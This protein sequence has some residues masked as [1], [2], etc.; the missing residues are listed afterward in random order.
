MLDRE[1]A[2]YQMEK[3]YIH[4]QGHIVWVLLS[5]SL[6]RD[7]EGAPLNFISQIQDITERKCAQEAVRENGWMLLESQRV[8]RVGSYR[9][10]ITSGGWTST[11]VLDEI[12]GITDPGFRKDIEGWLSLVHPDEREQMSAYLK[13]EVLGRRQDFDREYRIQRL[14]DH[15]ERWVHGLGELVADTGGRLVG[16]IGTL[17]DVTERKRAEAERGQV[18]Q[19]LRHSQKLEGIGRLA[20]GVAH[21]F[22]NVLGVITGFGEMAKR[23]LPPDHPVQDRL[24][25]MLKASGRAADLTRQMLAFSRK[26]VMHPRALDLNGVIEGSQKMLGRLIGADVELVLRLAPHLGTVLADPTQIGQVLM[27]LAVN[28]R[29]AMPQGGRLAFE[30]V[31]V[32][33]DEEYVRRHVVGRVGSYVMLA[34]SDTGVGMDQETRSHIFE[35][36]FTTKA[37]GKG[38]G[39]G[40]ATV[41]GIVKQSD[42]FIWVYSEPGYGA[43]FRIYL[44]RL[45]TPQEHEVARPE[46]GEA[47]RGTETVLVVEDQEALREVAQEILEQQGYRVLV[48]GHG[49]SALE[50]ARRYEGPIH[51]LLTD[52]VMPGMNGREL[53]ELLAG[54]RSGMRTLF[55]SGYTGGS[56]SDRG[57]LVKGVSLIE[58]PFNPDALARAVRQAL[59]GR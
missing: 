15:E 42:G 38:M 13:D 24:D 22:N 48:A 33:L 19:M 41:Y 21:D 51:L 5:V 44:P 47:P 50:L 6:V 45:D 25:E 56:L 10:D 14:S 30:T 54:E 53:A 29:D 37:E 16:M 31:N 34:V 26:Q 36:F 4:K 27:N 9:L 11:A 43:T 39:L 2:T 32:E 55:M 57:L 1:I 18:E 28:A 20:G 17:Q 23:Q 49:G 35:P 7:A 59:E 52:V 58:K 3:R 12:F 40:M 46:A 8:A